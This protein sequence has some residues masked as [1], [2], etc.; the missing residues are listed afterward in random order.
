MPYWFFRHTHTHTHTHIHTHTN[1]QCH[2]PLHYIYVE[3]Y[4]LPSNSQLHSHEICFLSVFD[5]FIPLIMLNSFSF[6]FSI[7]FGTHILPNGSSILLQFPSHLFILMMNGH[8]W[9]SSRF[10][11]ISVGL[12]MHWQLIIHQNLIAALVQYKKRLLNESRHL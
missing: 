5:S 1:T 9:S 11:S 7:L 8:W 4:L 6:T 2:L 3:L 12:T 10:R